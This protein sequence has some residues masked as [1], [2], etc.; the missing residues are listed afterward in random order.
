MP[1]ESYKDALNS[2]GAGAP[3]TRALRR[4]L[5]SCDACRTALAEEHALVASVDAGLYTIANAPNTEVPAS[6]IPSVRARFA[7][8]RAPRRN[9]FSWALAGACTAALLLMAF[10]FVEFLRRPAPQPQ[11]LIAAS[12]HRP[13]PSGAVGEE[14]SR[15]APSP[16]NAR[17]P[18][19]A[20]ASAAAASLAAAVLIPPDE[21]EAFAH[22]LTAVETHSTLATAVAK[23][24]PAPGDTPLLVDPIAIATLEV[25]P[26]EQEETAL[27]PRGEKRN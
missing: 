20:S 1:C 19:S 23:P 2:A 5:A 15:Y 18:S 11:A 24:D 17:K 8:E 6:L 10:T 22:F 9:L 16:Q 7:A 12:K 14:P 25:K 4:H 26:L 3:A 21:R 27:A 13:A